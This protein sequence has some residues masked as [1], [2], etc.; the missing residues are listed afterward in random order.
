V[1][2][3][4]GPIRQAYLNGM[5]PSAQRAT[6]LSTD[7]MLAS[8]GGV[9]SQPALG[10]VADIWGYPVSY[11]A[12]AAFQIVALPFLLLARGENAKADSVTEGDA[13]QPA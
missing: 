13:R 7:N 12:S 10:K 9:V 11:V 8:A 5:L 4:V 1:F 2:A 3:V 6:V